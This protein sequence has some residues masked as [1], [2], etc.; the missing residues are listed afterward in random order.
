MTSR[1]SETTGTVGILNVG[2]GDTKLS[3]DP[4][5]P[6]ERIRAARIVRDMLRR[7][8]ALLV[9][10]EVDGEKKFVRATDF[11]ETVCEYI[12]A[13]FDPIT[14]AEADAAEEERHDQQDQAQSRPTTTAGAPTAPRRGRPPG[15]R[16]VA[17]ESTRAV[18]VAPVAGG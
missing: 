5:N 3:F 16:A 6:A 18:V 12:V 1:L 9:E 13:D 10:V 4:T 2:D 11:D 8:Y 15:K 14:A 7:G 17:A